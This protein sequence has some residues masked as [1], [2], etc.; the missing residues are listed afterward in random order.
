MHRRHDAQRGERQ[1][2]R[3]DKAKAQEESTG[4]AREEEEGGGGRGDF[5]PR[6]RRYSTA[7]FWPAQQ[8]WW[9]GVQPVRSSSSMRM[10]CSSSSSI[11]CTPR[12][13][14]QIQA[15]R[16]SRMSDSVPPP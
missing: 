6:R 11:T 9:R 5:A 2:E 14:C 13:T 12:A 10:W 16:T 1:R 8:A 15:S 7:L 3:E 4:D